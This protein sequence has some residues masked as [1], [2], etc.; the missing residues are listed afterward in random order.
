MQAQAEIGAAD[1][2]RVVLGLEPARAQ[3]D[4]PRR[5]AGEPPLELGAPRAVAGHQN[6]EIGKPP[7]AAAPLPSRECAPRAASPRR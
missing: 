4:A 1:D 2:A 5:Q 6:H 7:R 3:L